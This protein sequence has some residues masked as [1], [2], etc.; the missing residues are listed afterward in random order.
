[1]EGKRIVVTGLGVV[2]PIGITWEVFWKALLRGQN[3]VGDITLF[4]AADFDTRFAAEVKDFIVEEFVD[5]KE[6]RRMDRFTHFALAA[7]QM[8][9]E[10]SKLDFDKENLTR[11]GVISGSGIGGVQTFE[12]E[13]RNLLE[14]GPKR[15]SPF[16]IPMMIPDI[17]SGHISIRYGLKGPNFST[18]SA[19]ASSSHSL[20]E[21][22]KTIQ[23]GDADIMLAGGSEALITPMGI[24]G[25]NTMKALST[26]NDDPQHASRPFDLERDGFVVGEGGAIIVLEELEH[27]QARGA[28][29]YA[30]MVGY[31]ATA[32]AYH[33]TAPVPGGDGAARAMKC[34][35]DDA[36]LQP[37]DVDYVNAHGTSTPFN[38]KTETEAI[39]TLFGAHA[40]KLAISSTKSMIGHLLGAS[41]AVEFVATVASIYN[42]QIHPTINQIVPDPECDL[43]YTP[44]K[45]IDK[46]VNVAI[47]NSF[48]FGGHN[49]CLV[50]QK[51]K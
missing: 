18:L 19:C 3:G 43:Y 20:G 22:F 40:Y 50:L 44:N 15:I 51:Y 38:D 28:P 41:G 11:I 10:D 37:E 13:Y 5:R 42:D 1:M 47:S 32:D 34:A 14:K 7:A 49:V 39:K 48:G 6:A 9:V 26:R 36:D 2:S 30:E 45:A 8:A 33:I 31:G 16:F 29:I 27:A 24:G 23:R 17:A 12:R 35:L 21:A 4:D 25:F 46:V